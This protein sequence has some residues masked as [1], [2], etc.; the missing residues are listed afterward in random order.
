MLVKSV[1]GLKISHT[2]KNLQAMVQNHSQDKQ[3]INKIG[4]HPLFPYHVI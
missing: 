4:I 2:K 1:T 3:I